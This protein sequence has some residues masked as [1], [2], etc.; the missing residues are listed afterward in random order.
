MK[1]KSL[2]FSLILSLLLISSC[3]VPQSVDIGFT[4]T[5]TTLAKA[6]DMGSNLIVDNYKV[7]FYKIEIGNSETDKATIWE[8]TTGVEQDLVSLVTFS[9]TNP[10]PIGNYDF[11]RITIGRIINLAGTD[12]G[13]SGTASVTVT[14]SETTLNTADKAVFL[15][16]VAGKA[17][18]EF[19]LDSQINISSGVNLTL[20]FHIAGTV[21]TSPSLALTA[22]VLGFTYQ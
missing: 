5:A 1:K 11:C 13:T 3:S 2:L 10:V 4:S 20:T 19:L 22:P 9:D 15:F 18:G 14:G 6:I 17:T 16:G 21:T 8:N 12:N 7:T